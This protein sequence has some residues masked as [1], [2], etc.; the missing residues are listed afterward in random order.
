MIHSFSAT[1][2][3]RNVVSSG[4]HVTA[5]ALGDRITSL[6]FIK[7]GGFLQPSHHGSGKFPLTEWLAERCPESSLDTRSRRSG[8]DVDGRSEEISGVVGVP[9]WATDKQLAQSGAHEFR[10]LLGRATILLRW[11]AITLVLN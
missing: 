4:R 5:A 8:R 9:R 7:A 2:P 1:G 6:H 10:L 3:H 11:M